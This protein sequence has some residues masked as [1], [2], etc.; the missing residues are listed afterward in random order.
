MTR[1]GR[2]RQP[3]VIPGFGLTFGFT[4]AYFS[5]IILVPLVALVLRSAGL[6]WNGF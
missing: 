2:F 4:L 6:G 3:S 1:L 5:L